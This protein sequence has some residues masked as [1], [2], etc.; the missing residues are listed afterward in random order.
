M[1]PDGGP[2]ELV[3]TESREDEI[4]REVYAARDAFAADHDLDRIYADLKH[5]VGRQPSP[6]RESAPAGSG[7]ASC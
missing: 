4:L 3:R 1:R 5:P 7:V 6:A 2:E